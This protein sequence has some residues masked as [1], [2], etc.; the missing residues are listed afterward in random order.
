[1]MLSKEEIMKRLEKIYA[2]IPDFEC[3]HC[4]KCCGPIIWFKPEEIIIRDYMKNHD[5]EHVVWSTEEFVKHDMRCP[6]L[7][8]DRCVIHPVRPIVCR[9]QGNVPELLCTQNKNNFIPQQKLDD[10]KREF[11][12]FV[13]EIDGMDAFY[14]TR[15]PKI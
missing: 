14:G 12:T 8:N 10:I 13:R 15:K 1:M 7:K 3:K 9:L 2:Q 6:Y 5:I 11:D 4:H